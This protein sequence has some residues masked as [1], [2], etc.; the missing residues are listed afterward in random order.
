MATGEESAETMISKVG[1]GEEEQGEN[2]Q[3]MLS[4]IFCMLILLVFFIFFCILP[5]YRLLKKRWNHWNQVMTLMLMTTMLCLKFQ[6]E[7]DPRWNVDQF[8]FS[9]SAA[10]SK[11]CRQYREGGGG[12]VPPSY[13]QIFQ[14]C[15]AHSVSS[16][17]SPPPYQSV[18][19]DLNV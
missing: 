13:S 15:E 11:Q 6:I 18:Q 9:A 14:D 8:Q 10:A 12:G 1:E 16:L 5:V 2:N 7:N 17:G 19:S 4:M 3:A